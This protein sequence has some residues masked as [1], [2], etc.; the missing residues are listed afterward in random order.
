MLIGVNGWNSFVMYQLNNIIVQ[1]A[2]SETLLYDIYYIS[3]DVLAVLACKDN[4]ARLGEWRLV[5]ACRTNVIEW[6]T[7]RTRLLIGF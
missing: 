7:V 1:W 6:K 2:S 3:A 4:I 5:E